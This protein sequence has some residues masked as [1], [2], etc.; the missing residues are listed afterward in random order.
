MRRENVC[1]VYSLLMFSACFIQGYSLPQQQ[2]YRQTDKQ[3]DIHDYILCML[4]LGLLSSTNFLQKDRHTHKERRK[5]TQTDRQI[6]V[7]K[8]RQI[9]LQKDRQIDLQKDRLTN[10]QTV[11]SQDQYLYS[12]KCRAKSATQILIFRKTFERTDIVILSI[13]YKEQ[14]I[15][16]FFLQ[17]WNKWGQ[18][19]RT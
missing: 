9:D 18:K 10:R 7:Q 2:R 3:T 11:K 4:H 5:D 17:V 19:I 12:L 14:K 1:V 15:N 16:C 6:D 13:I 8:D